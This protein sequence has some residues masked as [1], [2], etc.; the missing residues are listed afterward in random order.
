MLTNSRGR[1]VHEQADFAP[2]QWNLRKLT[3]GTY[4]LRMMT[5]EGQVFTRKISWLE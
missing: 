1:V 3:P 5:P 2:D 4:L